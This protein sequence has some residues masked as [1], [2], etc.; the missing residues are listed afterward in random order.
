MS[1]TLSKAPGMWKPAPGSAGIGVSDLGSASSSSNV[2][3]RLAENV[4]SSLLRYTHCAGEPMMGEISGSSILA[5]RVSAS[6][7]CRCLH[8]N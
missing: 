2:R 7:T 8:S 5:I 6:T 4:N 3:H 1:S